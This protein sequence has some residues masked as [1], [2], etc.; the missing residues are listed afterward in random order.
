ML[1]P[2]LIQI[3]SSS[4]TTCPKRRA[5]R[6][7]DCMDAGRQRIAARMVRIIKSG[8]P[9]PEAQLFGTGAGRRYELTYARR[10]NEER[11]GCNQAK[12]SS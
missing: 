11:G 3:L 8:G 6:P 12:P 1:H 9:A 10:P 7:H 2:I 4:C 5:A